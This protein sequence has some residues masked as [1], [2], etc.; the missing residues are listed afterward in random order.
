[1]VPDNFTI[2]IPFD[3]LFCVGKH[4]VGLLGLFEEAGAPFTL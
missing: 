2:F 1:M 4:G 3:L